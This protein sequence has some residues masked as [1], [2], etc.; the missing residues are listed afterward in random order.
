M[1][2]KN[3]S[4]WWILVVVI[5]LGLAAGINGSRALHAV[6][7]AN[8]AGGSELLVDESSSTGY[9]GESRKLIIPQRN[10]GS[11]QWI[12]QVQKM[13][14]DGSW[15]LQEVDYDNAP[16]GRAVLTASPYRWWLASVAWID[17]IVSGN[18]IGVSVERAALYADPLLQVALLVVAT[19][20]LARLFAGW[21]AA[22]FAL[23]GVTLFPLSG[24]FVPGQP[25]DSSLFLFFALFGLLFLAAGLRELEREENLPARKRCRRRF[26][27]GGVAGGLAAWI[28]A[29][30][31][32]TLQ[33]SVFLSA[34]VYSLFQR[35]RGSETAGIGLPWRSWAIGGGITVIVA[36]LVDRS[37]ALFEATAWRSD[38]VNPLYA[39]IWFGCGWLLS[40][41]NAG[42]VRNKRAMVGLLLVSIAILALSY[43]ALTREGAIQLMYGPVSSGLTRLP[44]DP[45]A[46]SFSTWLGGEGASLT[47]FATIL[48]IAAFAVWVVASIRS[49][50]NQAE[51]MLFALLCGPTSLVLLLSFSRLGWW[52]VFDLLLIAAIAVTA[53]RLRKPWIL[54]V[55]GT[56]GAASL[57]GLILVLPVLSRESRESVDRAELETLVER[58]IAGWLSKRIDEPGAVVLA[59][60]NV[61]ISLAYYGN[62][63]AIGT[64]YPENVDG[65]AAAV[66]LSAASTADEAQALASGR[67]LEFVVHPSWDP[68]LEEYARLGTN[69]PET[70]FIALLNRWLPPLWLKPVLFTLPKVG[71]FEDEWVVIF[72]R[73]DVQTNA[74]AIARLIEYFLDTG[75]GQL[76]MM[77]HSA[78]TNGFA[79]E[80]E[81]KLTT[82]ELA[83]ATGEQAKFSRSVDELANAIQKGA[84]DYLDWDLRVSAAL[85][86]AGANRMEV[87]KE[88]LRDCV[89]EADPYLVKRLSVGSLTGML[90]LAKI[91]N[92]EF[93]DE[94]T[95]ELAR[96]LLPAETRARL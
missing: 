30:S 37:P 28:G 51:R 16:E 81:T 15:R 26:L 40:M 42:S 55:G 88:L 31:G 47:L 65:F 95:R 20:F 14:S 48:P 46:T 8:S 29:G 21:A 96:S 66:R 35:F 57:L 87:A 85:V 73:S 4:R 43:V 38:F 41:L 83:F 80:I 92:L 50:N 91:W 1:F 75:R 17:H 32:F 7:V 69:Q 63:R 84:A 53:P 54:G 94:Q 33:A 62:L 2:S 70:S 78:L 11:Y 56:A 34:L 67:E 82:V 93:R 12:M 58:R 86:L 13:F 68:F 36:W 71:G 23:G 45:G 10:A 52:S 77:A 74:G 39:L 60:P 44:M 6:F 22:A 72:R 18:P 59:P 61:S 3:S 89:R 76:A 24:A 49:A 5:A 9:E 64:P 19:V 27:L 25:G 90:R 79:E